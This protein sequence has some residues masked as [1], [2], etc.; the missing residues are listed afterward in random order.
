VR[1]P[2]LSRPRTPAQHLAFA[3]STVRR[4][5]SSGAETHPDLFPDDLIMDRNTPSSDAYYDSAEV[6]VLEHYEI[7]RE[8][9]KGAFFCPLPEC[10]F[11]LCGVSVCSLFSIEC[12]DT[13]SAKSVV[14]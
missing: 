8:R 5:A 11:H 12:Y 7:N 13:G 4:E 9:H 14:A 2:A 3:P 10:S 6:E 1:Q